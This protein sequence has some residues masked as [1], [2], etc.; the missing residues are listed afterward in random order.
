MSFESCLKRAVG[1]K[2][3][4]G[5]AAAAVREA[6]ARERAAYIAQGFPDHVADAHA[7]DAIARTA[8]YYA[9]KKKRDIIIRKNIQRRLDAAIDAAAPTDKPEIALRLLTGSHG[10]NLQYDTVAG[11]RDGLIKQINGMLDGFVRQHRETIFG[12]R[13]NKAKM[14][15]V[16][17]AAFQEPVQDPTSRGLAQAID[18]VNKRLVKLYN[19]AG[20]ALQEMDVYGWPQRHNRVRILNGAA[21]DAEHAASFDAWFTD[22][23][24]RLDWSRFVDFATGRPLAMNGMAPSEAVQRE[25]LQRIYDNIKRDGPEKVTWRMSFGDAMKDRYSHHRTLHFKSA[26]DWF[27]YNEKYGVGDP[28]D[29]LIGHYHK[30]ARDIAQMR[31][32]SPAP[33]DG[34][35]YVINR[36]RQETRGD[37]KLEQRADRNAN[38]ARATLDQITGDSNVPVHNGIA[39]FF[40][41][42]R[43]LITAARLGSAV[44]TTASDLVLSRNAANAVGMN[45]GNVM[46]RFVKM[47]TDSATV[48]E[49]AQMGYIADTLA[50]GGFAVQRVAGEFAAP[51]ITRK[52]ASAVIRGQ[53]LAFWTDRLRLSWQVS[54]AAEFANM[55][56]TLSELHPVMRKMIEGRGITQA[57]WELFTDPALHFVPRPNARFASPSYF[58]HAAISAGVDVARAERIS[59]TLEG[60]VA[61]MVEAA[62]PSRNDQMRALMMGNT[63]PGTPMGELAR[64]MMGFKTFTFNSMVAHY[65]NL[66]AT[67]TIGERAWYIASTIGGMTVL[68]GVA[69]QLTEL[70]K[71]REPRPMDTP[72]FWAQAMLRG[73]GF[74]PVGDIVSAGSASWGGGLESYFAGPVVQAGSDFL[75]LTVGNASQAIRGE[76]MNLGRDVV[77]F[78]QGWDPFSSFWPTRA[79]IDRMVWDQ[80]QLLLDP[81]AKTAMD[82]AVRRQMRD[83]GNGEWWPSGQPM[84]FQ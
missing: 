36:V 7:V 41:A 60:I 66:Q 27:N 9:E 25:F 32:L 72:E 33:K 21:T 64:S 65:R 17:K 10:S 43:N 4:K 45:P 69:V 75:N 44:L 14:L 28:F 40:G 78:A 80:L 6:W 48:Q 62:V 63:R 42:T 77:R 68:G 57:D 2:Q 24:P 23:A 79:A 12:A 58:R 76:D 19:L 46:S 16:V 71:G 3:I 30:F 8:R 49:S 73:G 59:L 47:M 74:G 34:L 20:G 1:D 67:S 11:L 35:D 70:A 55:P 51:E 82:Q 84:P 26:T 37:P 5:K 61:E 50:E 52:L 53:G 39:M 31:V 56:R 22:I 81:E 54:S 13:S 18:A 83:Y 29:T 38:L 15:D